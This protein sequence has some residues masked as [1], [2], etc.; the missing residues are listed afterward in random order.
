MYWVSGV[1]RVLEAR[2]PENLELE[3]FETVVANVT[4]GE[5]LASVVLAEPASSPS[6]I[7]RVARNKTGNLFVTLTKDSIE[8]WGFRVM[9]VFW[10]LFGE[11]RVA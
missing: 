10:A 3:T 6:A 11:E 1:A 8:L 2:T 9:H 7:L 4:D 5:G